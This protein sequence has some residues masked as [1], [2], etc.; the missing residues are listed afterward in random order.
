MKPWQTAL[1]Q[2]LLQHKGEPRVAIVGVGHELRGDDA[3]GLAVVR[4]L[5]PLA[6][7]NLMLV[8]GGPAPENVT[9]PLRRFNP[10]LILFVD[11]ADIGAAP[12]TIRCLCWGDL[13][14]VSASTHTLPLNVLAR[15]LRATIGCEVALLGVQPAETG[16]DAP[17]SPAVA[18]A[19]EEMAAGLRT[20]LTV[21]K[22]SPAARR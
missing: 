13:D 6:R 22:T 9:G 4:A 2:T 5:E 11:A 12:G 18:A 19:V 14:G 3:A 15:Y 16:L 7:D 10:S 21:P 17:L 20:L 8:A 1:K